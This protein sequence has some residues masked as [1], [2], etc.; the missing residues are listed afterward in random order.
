MS[1]K[2]NFDE[3]WQ[4][5]QRNVVCPQHIDLPSD[6]D[7]FD[8]DP[9][10]DPDEQLVFS[11][12]RRTSH[13]KPPKENQQR[14]RMNKF[15]QMLATTPRQ[16]P[17]VPQSTSAGPLIEGTRSVEDLHVKTAPRSSTGNGP[18]TMQGFDFDAYA[19]TAR[20][21][22]EGT[23]ESASNPFGDNDQEQV[24]MMSCEEYGVG[25]ITDSRQVVSCMNMQLEEGD[26]QNTQDYSPVGVAQRVTV[27]GEGRDGEQHNGE[28]QKQKSKL[29]KG[30][31]K[32]RRLFRL[33]RRKSRANKA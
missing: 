1:D 20:A 11:S 4:K 30:L 24:P 27:A 18:R 17:T 22:M 31:V 2:S 26:E 25:G 32:M 5:Q 12:V 15:T 33:D 28:L 10:E 21:R 14:S 3:E 23:H 9:G 29:V 16:A 8:S 19:Q 7:L 6:D 13:A